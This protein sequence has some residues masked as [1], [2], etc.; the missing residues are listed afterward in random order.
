MGANGRKSA[1]PTGAL[2]RHRAQLRDEAEARQAA[3]DLR[4]AE[5]Q[6]ALIDSRPGA[7]R[8]ERIRLERQ[9]A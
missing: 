1:R 6:L 8:R 9:K 2:K 3:R 5:E 4:T 7:S